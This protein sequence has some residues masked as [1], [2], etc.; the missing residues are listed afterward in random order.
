RYIRPPGEP[1]FIDFGARRGQAAGG[2]PGSEKLEGEEARMAWIISP[3]EDMP[4]NTSVHIK[5]RPGLE[6]AFGAEKGVEERVAG[7]FHT[8]PSFYFVGI[9]C[10]NLNNTTIFIYPGTNWSEESPCNPMRPISLKFSTPVAKEDVVKGLAFTPDL[11]GGR[12]DVDVWEMVYGY[13]QIGRVNHNA[14]S[15][16][17]Q[18]LPFPLKAGAKY[19]IKGAVKDL[20]GRDLDDPV[21]ITFYIGHRP[22]DFKL[23]HKQAV[24]EQGVDS[25]L[26]LYITNIDEVTTSYTKLTPQG[27][28]FVHDYDKPIKPP[29]AQDV[30]FAIPLDIRQKLNGQ[31]GIVYGKIQTK[32]ATHRHGYDN[33]F[34]A[35][36]TPYQVL[37]KKGHFNTIVWV[38]DMKT[39]EPV[40]GARV[41]LYEDSYTRLDGEKI[42]LAEGVTDENGLAVLAG[43]SEYDPSLVLGSN[44][45]HDDAQRHFIQVRKG[46]RLAF[47]P[48]DSNFQ[49]DSYRISG[50]VWP[51]QNRKN[52]H[53][54][55]WGA[56]PQGIYRAGDRIEYK[57]Y[58]RNQDL[59][60][61]TPAPKGKYQL[62]VHDPMGKKIHE[63][64]DITLSEFGAFHGEFTTSKS[65]AVGW[66]RFTLEA[67]FV[68]R[69]WTPL[70]VLVS[71]FT[72]SPFK[73]E[74]S[75]NGDL[76]RAGDQMEVTARAMLHSG[77]PYTGASARITAQFQQTA[78]TPK[79]QLATGFYFRTGYSHGRSQFFQETAPMSDKG[80]LNKKI[81]LEKISIIHGRISVEAAVADD[82]GKN[83]TSMARI[84]YRGRDRLV[85]LKNTRWLYKSREESAVEFLV[86]DD[87]GEPA[88]GVDVHLAIV[89]R[90]I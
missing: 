53:I 13:T 38:T 74:T 16:Y 10:R 9:E 51:R 39:G 45:Y 73:V 42:T 46:A 47:V 89:R 54:R 52:D 37:V 21:D 34:L 22:P 60:T 33:T 31:S 76:F 84:E 67:D 57:I 75:V 69:K 36:V 26:P 50:S 24:L 41:S 88:P 19:S 15:R 27:R 18:R 35:Q 79:N 32:P 17:Y 7:Q 59:N 82:R 81:S 85:G 3:V 6:S 55:A 8:F 66:H 43:Y 14:N 23:V 78:F 64:K 4:L 80:E 83:V 56:T 87:L 62:T 40:S 25:E 11:A 44:W 72:P 90:E 29:K 1:F 48:L 77:G 58:V 63:Q 71:D 68:K 61:F 5:V 65:G 86:A 30:S 28:E 12:K 20:F 49:I 70:R 2:K